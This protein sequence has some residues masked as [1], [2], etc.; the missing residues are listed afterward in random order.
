[1]SI[2]Y[3]YKLLIDQNLIKLICWEKNQINSREV[4]LT[5]NCITLIWRLP[6]RLQK[7]TDRYTIIIVTSFCL[8]LR[9][10]NREGKTHPSIF[11]DTL[12]IAMLKSQWE[13]PG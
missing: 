13:E 1:M 9:E 2:L 5:V 7:N 6:F 3:Y 12:C 4:G 8:E 11:S 10:Q